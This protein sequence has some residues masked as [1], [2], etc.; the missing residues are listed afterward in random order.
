MTAPDAPPLA[1]PPPWRVLLASG[2]S[3][4]VRVKRYDADDVEAWPSTDNT[5]RA[6]GAS[7]RVTVARLAADLG[8]PV[9]EVLAP[10]E[11]TSH[12]REAEAHGRGRETRRAGAAAA[13]AKERAD[14]LDMRAEHEVAGRTREAVEAWEM[15]GVAGDCE[16][17]VL[18]LPATRGG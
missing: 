10:G 17:A 9:A 1:T 7:E 8:W 4:E 6:S 16:A 5:L 12:D 2:E 15:A 11:L 18:A 13:F 3:R 14:C